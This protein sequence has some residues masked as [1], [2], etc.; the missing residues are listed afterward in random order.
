[1]W[2]KMKNVTKNWKFDKKL[3]LKK[4]WKLHKKK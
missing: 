2:Q 3:Q 1:M 4:K